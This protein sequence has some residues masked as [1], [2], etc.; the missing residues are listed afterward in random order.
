MRK[1]IEMELVKETKRTYKFEPLGDNPNPMMIALYVQKHVFDK[2]PET[3]T[4]TVE[5]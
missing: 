5:A 2:R 1:Q 4:V 3:I